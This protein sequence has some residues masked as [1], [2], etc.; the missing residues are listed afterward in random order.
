MPDGFRELTF[1]TG[2]GSLSGGLF[3]SNPVIDSDGNKRWYNSKGELHR[4]DGPAI[5]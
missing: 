2:F 4:L 5:E 3:M 1:I